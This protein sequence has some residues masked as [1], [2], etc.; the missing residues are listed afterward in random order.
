MSAEVY[1]IAKYFSL[2]SDGNI[3]MNSNPNFM[4]DLMK[5]EPANSLH[6][7]NS[8]LDLYSY[9]FYSDERYWWLLML[10]NDIIDPDDTGT[11]TV[12]GPSR[13]SLDGLL[14]KYFVR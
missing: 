11:V 1:D 14:T 4:N 3:D 10:Y 13:S 8:P 6:E 7:S 9:K 5:L 12:V 2:D